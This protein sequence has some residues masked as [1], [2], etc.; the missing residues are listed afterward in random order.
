[1]SEPPYYCAQASMTA[2]EMCFGTAVNADIWL[3]VEVPEPWGKNAVKESSMPQAVKD[4]LAGL[5]RTSKRIRTQLIKQESRT[6]WPRQAFVAFTRQH[7]S[8]MVG[9]RID[10]YE[11]LLRLNA[12][13]LLELQVNLDHHPIETPIHLVCTHGRHDKCCAKFGFA[14][15]KLMHSI[16]PESVWQTSHVGG[17]RFASNVISFPT[18][19]YYGHVDDDAARAIIDAEAR[20]EIYL[21]RYRGRTCFGT[22]GQVAEYFVRRESDIRHVEALRREWVKP[23]DERT[24]WTG[25]FTSDD[26]G[27]QHVVTF[28]QHKSSFSARLTCHANEEKSPFEYMLKEYAELAGP[29]TA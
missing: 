17:D 9:S 13:E 15:Y 5:T 26:G 12:D 1:M 25:L 6:S 21:E 23:N 16:A 27:K 10:S 7:G 19:V 28:E 18:G 2:G 20:K 14:T 3:L 4:H 8:Y 11:E 22:H 29:Q 24:Q